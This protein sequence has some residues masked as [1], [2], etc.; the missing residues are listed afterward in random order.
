VRSSG[1]NGISSSLVENRVNSGSGIRSSSIRSNGISSLRECLVN[2]LSCYII[3]GAESG[4]KCAVVAWRVV[5]LLRNA[6]FFMQS[7]HSTMVG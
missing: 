4:T 2:G 6:S 5:S 7:T 1:S 3:A